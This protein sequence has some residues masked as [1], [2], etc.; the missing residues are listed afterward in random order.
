MHQQCTQC[1]YNRI[2]KNDISSPSSPLEVEP[3]NGKTEHES[4][5]HGESNMNYCNNPQ[6][7]TVEPIEL[8]DELGHSLIF[9]D[10]FRLN[11]T[12]LRGNQSV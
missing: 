8:C 10:E 3:H 11:I 1:K 7:V 9:R 5:S 12:K 6:Q 2:Q 4:E